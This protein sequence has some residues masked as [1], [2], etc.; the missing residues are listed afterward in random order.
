MLIQFNQDRTKVLFIHEDGKEYIFL[1]RFPAFLK[2]FRDQYFYAPAKPQ[3]IFNLYHRL[4]R[5]KRKLK[6]SQDVLDFL[7]QPF[8]LKPIPA[9]FK[10]H[11]TP[12]DFQEIS[13]RYLYTVGG[14]GL[15]LDPGMGKSKVILDFIL[16]MGFTKALIV[17]P[18]PLLFVWEDEIATHRPELTYHTV[19]TT[20]WPA[21]AVGITKANVTIINYNKAVAFKEQLKAAGFQFIHL[22]E[23]LIK[24]PSTDRTKDLTDLSYVIPHRAGGSGTLVNNS[25]HDV[26]APVRYLEPSLVSQ[27]SK[28]FLD[29]FAVKKTGKDKDGNTVN[30]VVAFKYMDEARS[31]LESCSI[32]M[33]KEKWLKLPP[34]HF[35]DIFVP[36]TDEQ[37]RVSQELA[38]NY[39]STVKGTTIEIDNALVMLSKL[40][41]ISNGFIYW[42]PPGEESEVE[43]ETAE[44]LADEPKRKKKKL[45]RQTI[46]FEDSA[47]IEALR[48]L[49]CETIPGRRAILWFNMEAEYTLIKAMLE[50]EGKSFLTIKGGENKTGEKVRTFN[51]DPSIDYLVCQARSVNYGI[52]V[53]GTTLEKLEETDFEIFPGISPEV[54]TQI[55]YSMNF[56]LEVYLQQQDRIH[57][58]GQKHDCD[59]YRIFAISPVEKRIRDAITEKLTIRHSLLIDIAEKIHNEEAGLV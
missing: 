23:F 20:D 31:I 51:T 7:N 10:F 28:K 58:L 18:K 25:V 17:C 55:F 49:T 56:S 57:R 45:K 50:R 15:L 21:E 42:T 54:H 29:H 3:L 22:D 9:S 33:T 38:R 4:L 26:F 13:L 34:K 5:A 36:L 11:T 8:A 37:R 30:R 40:Y 19:T 43:N 14:G 32:V 27:S 53:L 59:Y 52:T 46:F 41:Q 44:L 6:I 1:N 39:I 47:K 12:M 35:H 2:G 16:L 48:K 24:D